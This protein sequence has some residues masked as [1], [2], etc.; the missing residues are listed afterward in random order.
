[1]QKE[2][3]A[4][5]M[6]WTGPAAGGTSLCVKMAWQVTASVTAGIQFVLVC[7]LCT[8]IPIS[9]SGRV[10][11]YCIIKVYLESLNSTIDFESRYSVSK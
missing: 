1:M 10:P 5:P 11:G 2:T 8:V 7:E 4:P 6:G 9:V 3:C